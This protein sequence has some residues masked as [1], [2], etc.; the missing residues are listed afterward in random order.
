MK[1]AVILIS[2]A[3]LIAAAPIA[4]TTIESVVQVREAARHGDSL[5]P[6]YST[7]PFGF[8]LVS[9]EGE[10]LLCDERVPE[11][12]TRGDRLKGL[13]C[14]VAT[15][16][17]SWRNPSLLA[18]MPA[19]GPGE[20]I[21]MGSPAAT[22]LDEETWRRTALHEHFHQWQGQLPDIYQRLEALGLSKGDQSGMW[23]LNYPFPYEKPE[24]DAAY[25][26]AAKALIAALSAS[27]ADLRRN[28]EAY[29]AKRRAFAASVSEEEWRYFDFQLWK[30]GVARWTEMEVARRAG[31]K[32]AERADRDWKALLADLDTASLAKKQ[33]VGVYSY[34]AA[35]AAL[36]ERV[37]ADWRGCYRAVTTLSPCWDSLMP[38]AR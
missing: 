36:L 6:G 21:V 11:G 33:R 8:L 18:A 24:V 19:F 31:G 15:G 2:A 5:W 1:I 17:K 12:F 13:D 4:P 10:V 26:A 34:G 30:E 27:P 20:V 35:E 9:D 16:P 38:P 7:A 32:W 23:M 3:M 37:D 25:R 28:T 29:F 22:G 14:A